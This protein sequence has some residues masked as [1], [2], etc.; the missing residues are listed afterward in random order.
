M[1]Q[2]SRFALAAALLLSQTQPALAFAP[3]PSNP[4]TRITANARTTSLALNSLPSEDKHESTKASRNLLKHMKPISLAVLTAASVALLPQQQAMAAAPVTPIKNFKPPDSKKIALKKITDVRNKEK[5]KAE[6]AHQIKCEEIEESEG[7]AARAAYEKAVIEKKILDA[8]ERAL[9]RKKLVYGLTDMGLCPFVDIEGERQVYMF[10]HGIDLNRVPATTQQKEMMD[11]KRDKKLVARRE[12]ERFLIKSIVEDQKLQGNDPVKYLEENRDKTMEFRNMKNR[13]FD[14][15]VNKYQELLESQGSL[16]GEK[17]EAPFDMAAAVATIGGI[18]VDDVAAAKAAKAAEKIKIKAEKVAVKEAAKAEKLA[19]KESAKAEKLAAKE[20]AAKEKLAAKEAAETAAKEDIATAESSE[21]GP[22]DLETS[23]DESFEDTE[24]DLSESAVAEIKV[25][26]SS[27]TAMELM[28]S[29]LVPIIGVVGVG[30]GGFAFMQK[31]KAEKQAEEEERQRQFKL[32]MGL[33]GDDDDEEEMDDGGEDEPLV[34]SKVAPKEEKTAPAA[35][36]VQKKKK[37]RG[38]FSNKK[39]ARETDLM[40]LVAT[41]G[42]APEFATLLAKL[43]TF[44]APGRF[45]QIAA[46]PGDKLFNEFDLDEAKKMLIESRSKNSITDEISAEQFACVVNCMIID[47]IDLASSSL[48][49]K[50]KKDQVTVDALNVVMEFMDHAA[51][52]FDAVADGVV[53]NP[54]TYGGDLS[55][56]KLD[57]MF[58]IYSTA[59]MTTADGSVTQDRID[60]LQQVFNINDKRAE[61]LSQKA[62]MKNLMD[63]MKNG[64]EGEGGMEEMLKGMGGMEGMEG[65]EEMMAAMAGTEGGEGGMPGF[66]DG[67]DISPEQLKASVKM[68]KE[69]V[70]SGSVSKEE[71]ALVREQFKTLYGSDINELIKAAD[72]EG[73]ADE[74]GEDGAELLELFKD[75]LKE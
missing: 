17:A 33:E 5:M 63:M 54:V 31:A 51:S 36:P 55:K 10:D 59:G 24:T 39:N 21:S 23:G 72:E 19:A 66:G 64:G 56:G 47:I 15:V 41:D 35:E 43:L 49:M 26:S 12:K 18:E 25:E 32:I 75:I 29:P 70:D 46:L 52:L 20:V 68:M 69:L 37:R 6:M 7:R 50:D 45:P 9:N 14:A 34:V 11:L 53:I 3:M 16:S 28:N 38:F 48:G 22:D 58:A 13:Q 1:M 40:N 30:G 44:G 62:M 42:T 2:K 73:G 61:G 57:D 67:E 4:T 71:L 60:T 65:M 27:S 74:L 8:E